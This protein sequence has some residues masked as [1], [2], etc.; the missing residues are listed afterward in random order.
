M[1]LVTYISEEQPTATLGMLVENDEAVVALQAVHCRTESVEHPV[2]SSMQSL[3]EAGDMGL[4]LAKACA[5]KART[6]EIRRTDQ[7][8]LLAPLPCPVQI[9]DCLCFEEHLLRSME[10]ATQLTGQAP[11]L[12]QVAMLE[13][14]HQQ[15]I[16]YKA[17]RFAV[18]GPD[19][20]VVWPAY[21]KM[22]DYELELGMVLGRTGRDICLEDARKHIFGYT[23]FN[24]LSARD[25]QLAEMAGQLGPCKGKDFDGANVMG[26]CIVTA[27]EFDP[28]NARMT[29]LINGETIAEGNSGTMYHKFEDL[30]A[31]IS[32]SETLHAGEILGSGTVGKGSGLEMGRL[33]QAGDVVELTVDGIGTLRNRIL[34]SP[35]QDK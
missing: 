31:Y 4:A 13:T 19:V 6:G 1:K 23:I 14:F 12:N 7:L 2:L 15:P 30:I 5:G 26:P 27:D 17:N 24:D 33:L 28:E 29:V 25:A 8:Q 35:T 18:V 9:R 21:S 32:R 20:D 22:M 11:S 16:Y 34:T 10:A 3:I